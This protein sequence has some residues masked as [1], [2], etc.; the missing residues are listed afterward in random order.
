MVVAVGNLAL[1]F[2]LVGDTFGIGLRP[3][4]KNNKPISFKIE[5]DESIL[6]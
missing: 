5:V 4:K 1:S 2:G 6:Y 3:E